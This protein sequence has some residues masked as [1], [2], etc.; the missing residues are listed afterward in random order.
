MKT[1]WLLAV[2]IIGGLLGSGVIYLTSSQPRGEGITLLPPP[3]SAPIIVHIVGAVL[4]PG[5]YSLPTNSRQQDAIEAAGGFLSDANPQALNLAAPLQDGDRI[6]V[7]TMPSDT[8][9]PATNT[10][11]ST[12]VELPSSNTLI[13]IN[14]ASQAD[15]ENLPGIGP[16]KAKTIIAYREINGI[17]GLI[18]DIQKVPGIGP[19]TFENLKSLITIDDLY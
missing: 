8:P 16:V 4:D 13:N 11:K 6:I 7:P 12:I 1:W 18:E 3:T 19:K 2:G 10:S 9:T 15:L 14:T 17:F 5:V